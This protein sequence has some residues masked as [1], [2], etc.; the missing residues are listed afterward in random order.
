MK[1]MTCRQLG[2]A[3]DETFTAETFEQI[4]ALSQQHGMDMFEK[5]VA[6]HLAAM[7]AMREL[8]HEPDAMQKWYN[9]RKAEF[10]NLPE[11]V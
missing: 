5:Q 10:E 6:A 3:C 4:A 2:G 11:D 1:T 7:Q 8:M 9:E